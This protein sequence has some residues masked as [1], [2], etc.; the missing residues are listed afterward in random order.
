MRAAVQLGHPRGARALLLFGLAV[1]GGCAY[2][3]QASYLEAF[4]QAE[5][6]QRA[7]RSAEAAQAFDRA[8][9][10]TARPL[11]RDEAIYRGAQAWRRAGDIVTALARFEWLAAHGDDAAR[12]TRGE[13]EAIRIYFD[14]GRWDRGESEAIEVA[15]RQPAMGA[16]RRALELS[17]IEADSRDPTGMAALSFAERALRRLERTE[18]AATLEVQRAVRY[19]RSSQWARAEASYV[20]ALTWQYPSNPHWDDASLSLARLLRR[21]GRN[22]DALGVIERALAESERLV[23]VPGSSVRPK[24]PELA[25][26]RGE[27][28]DAMGR[29]AQAADA[30]HSVYVTFVRSTLRDNALAREIQVRASLGQSAQVCALNATLA[31]E[32]SCTRWGRTALESAR[33]C[34]ALGPAERV[35]CRDDHASSARHRREPS[36]DDGG[37]DSAEVVE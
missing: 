17:L 1:L 10:M 24:F 23:L 34:G 28:L 3:R 31:R 19:E 16:G 35:V 22:A 36:T 5:R 8:A 13:F 27:V 11:D 29:S 14:Q 30:F 12:R 6:A 33:N 20:R 9:A 37:M 21:Q 7:G 25:V 26:E 18:L 2:Q 15:V 32:F 4:S